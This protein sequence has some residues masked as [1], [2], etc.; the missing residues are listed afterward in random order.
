MK[1]FKTDITKLS[2]EALMSRLIKS[3][4]SIALAELY[5]RYG[6]KLLGYFINMFK[7][8]VALAEDFLQ[9]LFVKLMDKKHLF[10]TE[11]KFYTW[12]FT[13]ASNMCKT[14]FTKMKLHYGEEEII[15]G[16]KAFNECA[17]NL[18]NEFDKQVFRLLLKEKIAGLNYEHKVVFVL[19]YHQTFSLKEIATITETNIGTVKSRLFYAT[20]QMAAELKEFDPKLESKLFKIN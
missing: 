7:G 11:K 5:Q 1:L 17:T 10:D 15:E 13:I 20:K 14:H 8:D 6:K 16:S 9:D 3:N 19:R 2:D 12:V 18:H 4:D